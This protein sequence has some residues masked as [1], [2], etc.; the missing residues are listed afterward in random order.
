M[1]PAPHAP[2]PEAP[3]GLPRA[4]GHAPKHHAIHR[5]AGPAPGE[6]AWAAARSSAERIVPEAAACEGESEGLGF[7]IL[8]GEQAGAWLLRWWAHGDI[9]CGRL[10]R[11]DP[12]P[13]GSAPQGAR[14]LAAC[15]RGPAA[16]DHER[17]ARVRTATTGTPDPGAHL[18]DVLPA[19]LR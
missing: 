7:A 11:A 17:R 16:I 18:A 12:G 1:S 4:P 8:H 10:Q 2:R 13:T 6:A 3:A 19:G 14:P 15:V 5:P 9:P